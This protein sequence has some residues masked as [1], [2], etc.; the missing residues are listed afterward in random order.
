MSWTKLG[1]CTVL[2]DPWPEYLKSGSISSGMTF[3]PRSLAPGM[4][5]S[6]MSRPRIASSGARK[7]VTLVLR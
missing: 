1:I 5:I 6:R 4:T 7:L 3:I 2:A